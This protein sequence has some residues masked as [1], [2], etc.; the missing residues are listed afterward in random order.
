MAPAG[1]KLPPKLPTFDAGAN[2]H[3]TFKT[4]HGEM[5]FKLYA[6]QCPVTVGNFVGLATGEIPWTD[7]EGN[8]VV[9]PLY[10]GT[11]FHRI[12]KDFMLQGGDPNGN[13]TGGPGYRFDDEASALELQ[14]DKPGLLSMANSGPNTNGSQFFITEIATPWL[15]GRH[16]V[17]GEVVDGLDIL[18]QIAKVPTGF[19]DRPNDPVLL[20]SVTIDIG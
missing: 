1:P 14:H 16:A 4:N 19:Q 7:P 12:I 15:N 2:V 6:E 11:V 20:E 8:A 18:L 5:K 3:A 17:F 10:D 9:R 13:G